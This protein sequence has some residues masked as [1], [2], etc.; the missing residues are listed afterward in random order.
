MG[1]YLEHQDESLSLPRCRKSLHG[2][3]SPEPGVRH[4]C[5][6]DMELKEEWQEEDFPR[7]IPEEALEEELEDSSGDGRPVPASTLQLCG[8]RHMRKR[9]L[10]PALSLTLDRAE[11]SVISGE[12]PALTPDE[13]FDIDVDGLETPSDSEHLE[14]PEDGHEFE[15]EDD[16]PRARGP[17]DGAAEDKFGE[18]RVADMEDKDGRK[19][20][21][22]LS[23]DQ[24]HKVDMTV[25][26][27]YK[28]VISHGGYYGDGLNAV[29]MFASCYLPESNI[30]GYQYIMDNLFRYIVGTLDLMV[31]EN[32][33][34]VYL[35]GAT[36]RG[37]VP[38][39]GWIKQ[40]YQ[41]IDRRLKKN[42]KAL[43]ILHPT[44]Y[45]RALL[46]IVRPFIS[47]KFGRKVR[48]MN[49]LWELSQ[50]VSLDQIHI[51]ECVRQL[52]QELN[53]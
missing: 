44:W 52:D 36:P 48:F 20:R 27:P 16:L 12:C 50:L 11:G 19:W 5:I 37:K 53:G 18:G 1:T 47:S 28:R 15:W 24:E 41:T 51:P 17:D 3:D 42:L 7:P 9:L 23:G 25:I 30:P 14:I 43:I 6:D 39:M 40:C 34:L 26:E 21:I 32:Y 22:F 49:S 35:N 4:V 10:A 8:N 13:D 2:Q 46:A 29:I 38:T 45:M 33:M 31:A